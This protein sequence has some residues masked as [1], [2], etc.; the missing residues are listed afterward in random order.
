L[1]HQEGGEDVDS[2]KRDNERHEELQNI[3]YFLLYFLKYAI[4]LFRNMKNI[5]NQP[6]QSMMVELLKRGKI[7][8]PPLTFR[9]L[10]SAPEIDGQRRPGALLEGR[11]DK[12]KAKF[13]VELK[14]LS[15]PKAFREAMALLKTSVLPKDRWPMLIMPFLGEEQL[16]ELE[17]E[18]ISGIDL[19]GN[20]IVVAPGK[21]AIF[22]SGQEN[23]F[24]SYAPIKN[25][26]RKKSSMIG[27][28][29]L[30]RPIYSSV[31]EVLAE[32]KRR[33]LGGK[34]FGMQAP[35]GATVSKVLAGL[36]QDLVIAREKGCIR[37]LQP[38]T[39]L[40]KLEQNYTA[41][42]RVSSITLKV[43]ADRSALPALLAAEAQALN[44][45][46]AATGLS[47]ASFYAVMQRDE[48]L[49]VN[50]PRTEELLARLPAAPADRFPNLEIIETRE[51]AV[52]FDARREQGFGWASPVQTFLELRQGDKRD[53]E[54]AQQ[55]RAYILDHVRREQP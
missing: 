8:L 20:G 45:P 47:S 23:R 37:L 13:A 22:R 1:E 15:T 29:F 12:A 40:D 43:V 41:P 26:Y 35:T 21:M 5:E 16:R 50:C 49:S 4:F 10:G 42:Q 30:A 48:M 34:A 46:L 17:K 24:R 11:W 9:F 3:R 32:I 18:G 19:C 51:P 6:T 7:A 28:T 44:L 53:Q 27:R 31:N 52:Y 33:D 25:I 54:A 14:S 38:E 39:L 55:M 2:F 36:A